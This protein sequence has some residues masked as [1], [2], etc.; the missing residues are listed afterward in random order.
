MGRRSLFRLIR[1]GFGF[2]IRRRCHHEAGQLRV[3]L[4]IC[5]SF[6][7]CLGSGPEIALHASSLPFLQVIDAVSA[8]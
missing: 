7:K 4:R 3:R 1:L 8:L 2:H 5:G 6:P